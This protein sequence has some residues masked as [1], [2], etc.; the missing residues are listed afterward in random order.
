[1]GTR[2]RDGVDIPKVY[3]NHIAVDDGCRPLCDDRAGE[4]PDAKLV[5]AANVSD[6]KYIDSHIDCARTPRHH[7]REVTAPPPACDVLVVS[8]VARRDLTY[9]A[10]S[11]GVRANGAVKTQCTVRRVR[12]RP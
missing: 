7:H 10:G 8:R 12:P 1:M 11:Q 2:T 6:A 3:S 5:R 4:V 9:E